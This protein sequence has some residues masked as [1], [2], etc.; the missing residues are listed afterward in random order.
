M[1]TTRPVAVGEA[2]RVRLPFSEVCAHMRVAGQIRSVRVLD[3]SAQ[4]RNDDGTPFSFPIT[5]H[6]AGIYRDAAG[7]FTDPQTEPEE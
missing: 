6:E 1:I 4:I 2:I 5:H 7:L 3:H